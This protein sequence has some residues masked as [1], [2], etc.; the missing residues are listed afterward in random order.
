MSKV[1]V[2]VMSREELGALVRKAVEEAV[3]S[4]DVVSSPA[5]DSQLLTTRQLAQRLGISTNCQEE[6]GRRAPSRALS[7]PWNTKV[8]MV[9]GGSLDSAIR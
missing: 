2:V 1:V 7:G 6:G 9:R 4:V 3:R 5:R 8:P